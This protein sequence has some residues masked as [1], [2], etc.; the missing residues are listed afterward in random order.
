MCL[1][2]GSGTPALFVKQWVHLLCPSPPPLLPF[3][4]VALLLLS[5][6]AD[7]GLWIVIA[8]HV[9]PVFLAEREPCF[10][11][12]KESSMILSAFHPC[13]I[14]SKLLIR[15]R[16]LPTARGV[17]RRASLR[18]GSDGAR[19]KINGLSLPARATHFSHLPQQH[20]RDVDE[21]SFGCLKTQVPS[22]M[23]EG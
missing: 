4:P 23:R 11:R 6:T 18:G 5:P 15:D 8:L 21:L 1:G 20:K 3:P 17:S 7:A 9:D 16:C 2:L 19:P 14:V 13:C 12:G 22:V 10:R